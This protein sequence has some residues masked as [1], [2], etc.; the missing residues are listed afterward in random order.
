[1]GGQLRPNQLSEWAT[2]EFR[3]VKFGDKRLTDRLIKLSDSL[4][5]LPESSINQAC[6]RWSETKAAYR[7]FQNENVNVGEIL[8]AHVKKTVERAKEHK[9]ILAIQDTSYISY[10]DHDKTTGLCKLTSRMGTHQKIEGNGLIM[11]TTLATTTEGLP[12][13]MLDQKIS[14]RKPITAEV[15]ALKK[16]SHGNAIPIEQKESIRWLESLQESSKHFKSENIRV[17]TICDR[18]GDIYDFFELAHN[19][20]VSVLVRGSQDRVVNKVSMYSKKTNQRLW[21]VVRNFPCQGAISVEIPARNNKPKRTAMLEVS[22]G[23]F[24]M[25]IP[26]NNFKIRKENVSKK[27][28]ITSLTLTAIYVVE[29]TPPLGE[30]ALEWL[31]LTNLPIQN[32]DEAVEKIRW[33]CLRWKIETM[34][35]YLKNKMNL[36]HTRHRSPINAFVHILST[37]ISYCLK[38]NKPSIN[39]NFDIFLN[40]I[41]I[42]N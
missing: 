33:Y 24:T 42:P 15:K 20:G 30:E 18:E 16:K 14:S 6:G 31:L 37:F 11:H 28:P 7:F 23:T 1:M 39:W 12:L 35:D 13:G 25:P 17:V 3:D 36:E 2:T 5:N 34:F 38:K 19:I 27:N 21:P 41:L 26:R 8:S 9:T 40:Y 32:F 29:K 4:A 10:T 22:F